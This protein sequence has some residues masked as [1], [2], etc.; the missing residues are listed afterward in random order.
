MITFDYT[1]PE[2][3]DVQIIDPDGT[4]AM[5]LSLPQ[6]ARIAVLSPEAVAEPLGPLPAPPPP[7]AQ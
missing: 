4:V 3:L 7:P 5:A 6:G 2:A 1:L